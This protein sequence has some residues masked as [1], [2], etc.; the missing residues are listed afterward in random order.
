MIYE[1]AE[2][3]FL[4]E[5]AVKKYVSGDVLDVGCGSGILSLV[6]KSK[7]CSVDSIDIDSSC[8]NYCKKLGLN[9]FVSDLF[10]NVSKKYDWIIFNPPY[11]PEDSLEDSESALITTGGKKG[12]EIVEKFL[13][14]V[15]DY[16]KKDGKILILISSLT[17]GDEFFKGFSYEVVGEKKLFF[18]V[19]KVY[20]LQ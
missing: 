3:S 4:L 7:D 10:S 20:L 9:A 17:G 5:K 18:E 19:L 15:R 1:P 11:L 13:K 12:S 6:A 14:D 8:V 2:D 16:L